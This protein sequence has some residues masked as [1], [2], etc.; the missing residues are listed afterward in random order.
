[1]KLGVIAH[2]GYDGLVEMIRKLFEIAPLIDAHIF[3]EQGITPDPGIDKALYSHLIAPDDLDFVISLGGDGTMLRAARFVD[4]AAVPILGINLGRLGFLTSCGKSDFEVALKAIAEGKFEIDE[5]MALAGFTVNKQ[6]ESKE[7]W[8]ALNDLVMHKGGF[9]RVLG[10]RIKVNGE[11]LGAYTA[12]GIVISSPTGSTAYSL[13]A[14]GP[15]VVPSLDSIIITPISPHALAIRP[16]VL[17][18]TATVEIEAF[19]GPDEVL[20]TADGQVGREFNNG[21]ILRVQK[22]NRGVKIVRF[23]DTTFFDLLRVKLGWGGLPARD[24]TDS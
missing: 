3:L 11:L 22:A 10:M 17:P 8:Y 16:L 6:G 2:H 4:G 13:S 20:I 24:N 12:D 23:T 9:A 7:H 19:D 14:G 21:D 18:P 1:M 15:L 5:R